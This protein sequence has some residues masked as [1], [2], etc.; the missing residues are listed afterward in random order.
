MPL[1]LIQMQ[2][3]LRVGFI[4]LGNMGRPMAANLYAKH[5]NLHLFVYNRTPAKAHEFLAQHGSHSNENKI[6]VCSSV[7]ELAQECQIV[8]SCLTDVASSQEVFVGEE[9]LCKHA[10]GGQIFVDHST[11]DLKTTKR[12]QCNTLGIMPLIKFKN[13]K[14]DLIQENRCYEEAKIRGCHF[15]DAPISGGSEGAQAASLSVSLLSLSLSH[16]HTHT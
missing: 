9:G 14:P 1:A 4:G 15:I 8:L 5:P 13:E 6:S 3:P 7:A 16:T 10:A 12:Y 11:V 2:N